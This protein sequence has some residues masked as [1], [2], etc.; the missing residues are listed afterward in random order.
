LHVTQGRLA[1]YELHHEERTPVDVRALGNGEL[2]DSNDVRMV[3]ALAEIRLGSKSRLHARI[4][5][6]VG[7]ENLD[8]HLG[9]AKQPV[10]RPI[11]LAA[12]PRSE[13]FDEL[14]TV[15]E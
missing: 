2:E 10:T 11:D 4:A 8:G 3:D 7:V 6:E 13:P 5:R 9:T 15:V 1:G 14:V 12:R